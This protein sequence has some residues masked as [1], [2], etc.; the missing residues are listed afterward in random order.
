M[1]RYIS[2]GAVKHIVSRRHQAVIGGA[3]PGNNVTIDRN[4]KL[5]PRTA[6]RLSK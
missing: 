2:L 1:T 5:H 6:E 3:R 4:K